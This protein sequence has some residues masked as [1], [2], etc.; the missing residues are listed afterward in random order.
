[1]EL[2]S[3]EKRLPVY[4]AACAALRQCADIDEVLEWNNRAEA[5]KAY[6]KQAKNTQMEVDASKIRLR[7]TRRLGELLAARKGAG[8]LKPGTR[9]SLLDKHGVGRRLSAWAQRIASVPEQKF[10]AWM[11]ER[12]ANGKLPSISACM[13]FANASLAQRKYDSSLSKNETY[14]VE[15]SRLKGAW[16]QASHTARLSFLKWALDDSAPQTR[17]AFLGWLDAQGD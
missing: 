1:M 8:D 3:A 6:A 12:T 13:A 15:L 7:A 5:I 17:Q 11:D 10:E 16:G 14:I 2:I 9:P 4:A